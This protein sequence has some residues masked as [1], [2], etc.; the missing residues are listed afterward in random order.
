MDCYQKIMLRNDLVKGMD[1][2]SLLHNGGTTLLT[3]A[4]PGSQTITGYL[5]KINNQPPENAFPSNWDSENPI[6]V[7]NQFGLGTSI[8]FSNEIDKLNYTIGHPDYDQLLRNS[9][10]YLLRQTTVLQ[11]DAP[12]SVHVYLNQSADS[13]KEFMLSLVNTSSGPMRPIRQLIPM[14]NITITLPFE[15][16]SAEEIYPKE[17]SKIS[18]NRNQLMID[19]LDE[20]SSLKIIGY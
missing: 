4:L 6:M 17:I 11:T 1:Q 8:Y 20:F 3:K 16:K 15:I 12:P 19:S 18:T 2:T 7:L 9:I 10:S 13:P 14:H 5:P